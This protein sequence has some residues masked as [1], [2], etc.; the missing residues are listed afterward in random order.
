MNL[1]AKYFP[2]YYQKLIYKNQLKA[3]IPWDIMTSSL[4]LCSYK[5]ESTVSV[6]T[7]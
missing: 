5:S 7:T 6:Y 4:K 1:M 2:V 3:F